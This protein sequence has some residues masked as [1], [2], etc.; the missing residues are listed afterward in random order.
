[1]ANAYFYSNVA[2]ANT[3]GNGGGISSGAVSM[4]CSS[5]PSGYPGSY[6]FKLRLDPGLS[7][8]EVVKV[9]SGAGTSGTPWA[10]T[11]GWDGTTAVSHGALAPVQHGMSA[12]DL[13]LSRTHENSGSGS[14]VHGLPTS[15]WAA[16]AI[17]VIGENILS[18]SSTSVVTFSS[19]PQSY[20]HLLLIIEG[21]MTTTA[22]QFGTIQ[23][24]VNGDSAA[25]YSGMQIS[26]NS[27][28]GSLTGALTNSY[29]SQTNWGW[30]IFM[31]ASQA[32][33]SVNAGGGYMIL[34]NYAGTSYNK[35]FVAHSGMGN[36]TNAALAAWSVW[37]WYN[38][39][40]QVGITTLSLAASV[41]NF[42]SAS[43]FGL[44]GID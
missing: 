11:R 40:S 29:S 35:M 18:N 27:L 33:S 10:I 34:P 23:A 31:A 15:A 5:T 19:I 16:G 42:Q 25:K 14:G 41:G 38:P 4:F 20:A 43:F 24:T 17:A 39:S 22:S 30:T 37:G 13:T 26:A 28:S 7:T 3:I 8:E 36:G 44:Y 1:M 2:V 12:E 9:N 32:G 21:R 6:P